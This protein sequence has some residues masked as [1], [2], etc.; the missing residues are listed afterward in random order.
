LGGTLFGFTTSFFFYGWTSLFLALLFLLEMPSIF[1]HSVQSLSGVSRREFEI[2]FTR[3]A[4]VWNG[5]LKSTVI[6]AVL[7]SAFAGLELYLMGIPYAGA[8]GVTAGFLNLIPTFGTLITYIMIVIVTY[9]QG[10]P[11]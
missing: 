8:I 11:G 1:R 6:T 10:R 5:W 7:I 3:M 9:T 4:I 2:L